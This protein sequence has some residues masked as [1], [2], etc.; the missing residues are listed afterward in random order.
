MALA[1]QPEA[2]LATSRQVDF[3]FQLA[4]Q[5][6]SLGGQRMKLLATQ[7]YSR[8]LEELT[9]LEAAG[10][11]DLFKEVRAGTRQWMNC[12]REQPHRETGPRGSQI[13]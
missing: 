10:L 8:P 3:V 2:P 13:R 11:I 5:I 1:R 12:W 9:T 6:G 7:L 4:R